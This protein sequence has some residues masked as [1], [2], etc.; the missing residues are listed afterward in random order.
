MSGRQ[1]ADPI[2]TQA[3]WSGIGSGIA[4]ALGQVFGFG[5]WPGP[6]ATSPPSAAIAKPL[7]ANHPAS[8]SITAPR[9]IAARHA[10]ARDQRAIAACEARRPRPSVAAQQINL[11]TFDVSAASMP[12]RPVTPTPSPVPNA[13]PLAAA[14]SIPVQLP[15]ASSPSSASDSA[16]LGAAA[17]IP[18]QLPAASAQPAAEGPWTKYQP[19]QPSQPAPVTRDPW[20]RPTS[21]DDKPWLDFQVAKPGASAQA[22]EGPW[23]KYQTAQPSQPAPV[24]RDPWERPENNNAPWLD[25]QAAKPEPTVGAFID[26]YANNSLADDTRLVGG[27]ADKA[28][29]NVVNGATLGYGDK[30]AAGLDALTGRSPDYATA[31]A[32]QRGRS[33]QAMAQPGG[34][35]TAEQIA[36]MALPAGAIGGGAAALGEAASALPFGLG[37]LAASP[38]AQAS[39]TGAT[40]GGIN[41][42]GNDQPV[43]PNAVL[44]ALAG[45]GGSTLGRAV[46]ALLAGP[47]G[48]VAAPST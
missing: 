26:P 42:A 33:A 35:G 31:L 14:A 20:E 5:G 37:R 9:A 39:A 8:A 32:D 40:V 27:L 7:R 25:Y 34:L 16:A 22:A 48:A 46:G 11:P 36:G 19:A 29:R 21:A 6:S 43:A 15:P 3:D 4:N 18:V 12:S 45:A 41:A 24:T 13:A 2:Y 28:V 10:I 1:G 38:L 47:A 23:T 30:I 17:S 44:G